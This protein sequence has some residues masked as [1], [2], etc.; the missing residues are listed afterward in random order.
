MHVHTKPGT[1]VKFKGHSGHGSEAIV[2]QTF[3]VPGQTYT[4]KSIDIKNRW[5]Q[6]VEWSS[7][8]WN[9]DMFESLD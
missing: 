7:H 6:L 5:V 1:F 9:I 2:A 8:W 3:L 4:I